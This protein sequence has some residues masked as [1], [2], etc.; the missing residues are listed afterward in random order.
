MNTE[1]KTV[2]ELNFNSWPCVHSGEQQRVGF[3]GHGAICGGRGFREDELDQHLQTRVTR[4][5]VFTQHQ[6]S[7]KTQ[8]TGEEKLEEKQERKNKA[9][10]KHTKKQDTKQTKLQ[11]TSLWS[12]LLKLFHGEHFFSE[13]QN[14]IL[15]HCASKD[16]LKIN[17]KENEETDRKKNWENVFPPFLH[18][19]LCI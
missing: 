5:G 6:P 10:E 11:F 18:L 15:A 3:K 19:Y 16:L 14:Q 17:K 13:L 4:R 1:I 12:H 7:R 9:W 8:Q 2:K